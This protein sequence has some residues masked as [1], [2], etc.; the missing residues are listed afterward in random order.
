M[1]LIN[2]CDGAKRLQT[3]PSLTTTPSIRELL[4]LLGIQ[5]PLTISLFWCLVEAAVLI[6]HIDGLTAL[7]ELSLTPE[8]HAV[9]TPLA[10]ALQLLPQPV[11]VNQTLT[12]ALLHMDMLVQVAVVNQPVELRPGLVS[13]ASCS[14]ANRH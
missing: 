3:L 1:I 11:Y 10:N 2:P 6:G 12:R 8:E 13:E 7:S 4:L 9:G 5:P 14:L